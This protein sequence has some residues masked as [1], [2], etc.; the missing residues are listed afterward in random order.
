MNTADGTGAPADPAICTARGTGP[1]VAACTAP[2]LRSG[3]S[4]LPASRRTTKTRRCSRQVRRDRNPESPPLHRLRL[5]GA[6]EAMPLACLDGRVPLPKHRAIRIL[7]VQAVA[8]AASEEG[9][10]GHLSLTARQGRT[11]RSRGGGHSSGQN[12]MVLP[13]RAGDSRVPGATRG[14]PRQFE[15]P[16]KRGRV[17][18][19]GKDSDDLAPGTYN[20]I[21]KQAELKGP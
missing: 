5:S 7:P 10:G 15:H 16:V 13:L 21:L 17:T 12:R 9:S 1:G 2:S 18:V 14:S 8:P 4:L 19:A 6:F 3:V 11:P 20:S